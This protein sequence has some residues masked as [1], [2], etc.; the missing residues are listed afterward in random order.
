MTMTR[1][2][3]RPKHLIVTDD[4]GEPKRILGGE[5]VFEADPEDTGLVDQYGREIH[6]VT[7]KHPIGF[8]TFPS[9]K[10]SRRRT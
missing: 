7:L 9:A 8:S 3:Y 4:D 2:I 5:I 1:R 6:R 10:K